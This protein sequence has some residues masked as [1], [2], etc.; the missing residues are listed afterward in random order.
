MLRRHTLSG[1]LSYTAE[2]MHCVL[3]TVCLSESVLVF[4]KHGM[5]G[6]SLN[7]NEVLYYLLVDFTLG[8]G[9]LLVD[10]KKD[11]QPVK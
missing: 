1:L 7:T 8:L 6:R 4:Y 11:I 5:Q 3:C 2:W 10:V 9:S